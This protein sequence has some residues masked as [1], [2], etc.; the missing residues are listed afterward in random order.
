[1]RQNI[2]GFSIE[3]RIYVRR[4]DAPYQAQLSWRHGIERDDVLL[5]GPFGQGL[6]ELIRDPA[7]ARLIAADRREFVA[8]DWSTLSEQVF[9]VALPLNGMA[10]WLT[11]NVASSGHD[12]LNRPTFAVEDG[13]HIAYPAY[14]SEAPN[15]LP[16]LMELQ[17]DDIEVRLKIDQ[18]ELN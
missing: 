10:R 4:G 17:R 11:G 3:A 8:P 15:A 13:W 7:G 9:G 6:A 1:M 12:A 18:W 14:E 5:T 2:A 16:V